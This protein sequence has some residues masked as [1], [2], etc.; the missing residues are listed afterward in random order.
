M[1]VWSP[2]DPS[3]NMGMGPDFGR[4][5]S[6]MMGRQQPGGPWGGFGNRGGMG[7][8]NFGGGGMM[9]PGG[10]GG[11]GY[12][13]WGGGGFGQQF[14][15]GGYNAYNNP[16]AQQFQQL[17]Q[18]MQQQ[19]QVQPWDQSTG[20]PGSQMDYEGQNNGWG[21]DPANPNTINGNSST[22]MG[23]TPT[24]GW[25]QGAPPPQNNGGNQGPGQPQQSAPPPDQ[26]SETTNWDGS[27][28]STRHQPP[29]NP[30]A[31]QPQAPQPQA[32]QP[33][34][35]TA[36]PP[37]NNGTGVPPGQGGPVQAQPAQPPQGR[38]TPPPAPGRAPQ[39]PDATAGGQQQPVW[40]GIKDH[41]TRHTTRMNKQ[42]EEYGL[43][44]DQTQ[45]ANGGTPEFRQEFEDAVTAKQNASQG[46]AADPGPQAKT[47]AQRRQ[48][49]DTRVA[50]Q[51]KRKANQ[52]A[53]R[54]AEGP[55]AA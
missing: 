38:G 50:N 31:P 24:P 30:H 1:S 40:K 21:R 10:W 51:A 42:N 41:D 14:G 45:F 33:P 46:V 49:R 32:P 2:N 23:F 7:G 29:P 28:K 37:Q 52:T 12:S 22:M 18:Q 35:A 5:M 15:Q 19:N 36:T 11:G 26:S 8:G 20:T 43:G 53:R 3:G 48:R 55:G 39:A 27:S 47:P 4:G 16:F 17:Q 34:Q 44:F 9:G 13:P 25:G 54:A 6:N